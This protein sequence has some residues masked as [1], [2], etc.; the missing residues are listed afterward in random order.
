MI[1]VRTPEQLRGLLEALGE[2]EP[3]DSAPVTIAIDDLAGT[4]E[5]RFC[6][7]SLRE[8]KEWVRTDGQV[9]Q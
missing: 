5:V 7:G 8:S 4:L 3:Q 9:V 1:A 6:V 2:N